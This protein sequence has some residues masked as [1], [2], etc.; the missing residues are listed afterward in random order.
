MPS[1]FHE[2]SDRHRYRPRS[3]PGAR[4]LPAPAPANR[5]PAGRRA[6]GC[7]LGGQ[8][9][10]HRETPPAGH[11]SPPQERSR[12]RRGEPRQSPTA[13]R[14][15]DPLSLCNR[16]S[17][18]H[19]QADADRSL[20]RSRLRSRRLRPQSRSRRTQ[21]SSQ[22]R[23]GTTRSASGARSHPSTAGRSVR[24][25][26]TIRCRNTGSWIYEPPQ[27]GTNAYASYLEL[28]WPGA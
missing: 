12:R 24:R 4:L 9:F 28:A 6:S 13:R 17:H 23:L 22:P 19:R 15:R 3:A 16:E 21:R 27:R 1:S 18:G 8:A 7:P 2:S 10:G 11:H 20:G 5:G 14:S 25:R 26:E